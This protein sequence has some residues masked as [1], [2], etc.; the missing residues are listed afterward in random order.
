MGV[1]D[2]FDSMWSNAKSTFGQ[3]TPQEGARF[4]NSAQLRQMQSDV[5]SARPDSR[6]TGSA[7]DSYASAN[8]K[9]G[10]VLGQIADLDQRLRTEV[11]RSAQVVNAGRQN[12]DSV[13]QWVHDAAA[14]VPAGQNRDRML[15][16]IVS[17]GA[18][19]IADILQK[20]N[21]D[22]NTIAGRVRSLSGE[23]QML[24]GDLKQG[25]GP[26]GE[27]PDTLTEEE[28][29]KQEEEVKKRAQADVK[30]A[31]DGDKG[32]VQR[33]QN[34]LN[35]VSNE[36]QAGRA[37]LNAEQQAYLS[38]MQAQQKLRSVA[39]LEETANNGARGI[40]AD[41]WQ[42]MSNPKVEFPKT[43]SVDGALQSDEMINGGFDQ[44]PDSVQH[45][46]NSP[47]T[48]N[49]ENLQ[50]VADIVN[51]GNDH[52]QTNTDLDRGLMHKV[53]DMME[54]PEWRN[55]DPW[56][57]PIDL[58]MPWEPEPPPTHAELERT[59]SSVME[60][61]SA[62]HQV[63]H[64]AITGQVESGN[65]FRDQFKVNSEHLLYNLTH[66]E[67]DDNGAAAGALFDWTKSAATGPE[68]GIAAATASTYAE[69][70][71]A[72][73]NDLMHLNGSNV[74]GLDGVTRSGRSILT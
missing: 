70:I 51:G 31:L 16:P 39:Q 73:S 46:I 23:Y 74:I 48:Q 30:A 32:A 47:G 63:V 8:D 20:S 41:S 10:R 54:S 25:T 50:K 22:L 24:G 37:K 17:K 60:A 2:G 71:G 4:D 21:S 58:D 35:T 14:T 65:E 36:Q 68:A 49:S 55:G 33:V 18:A 45:T 67:W 27:K 12:L 13:R 62:D 53:A 34:V 19:E 11:D 42:L 56:D 1:V 57:N 9:Q 28:R 52:F 15:Y 64:D 72:H 38:Q 44:L 43:E 3:G 6:W 7:S 26:D 61:V 66:E 59:A 40:M 5:Y 29:K 69:Y